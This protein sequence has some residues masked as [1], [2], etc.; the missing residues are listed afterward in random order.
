MSTDAVGRMFTHRSS[1]R[2][3]ISPELLVLQKGLVL[4]SNSLL[5]TAFG[6]A[7]A[8]RRQAVWL[9][10][11][12]DLMRLFNVAPRAVRTSA[13]RLVDGEWLCV[14][15]VGRRS[16]YGLSSTGMLRVALADRR[17][18]EFRL[19]DWDGVWT[20]VMPGATLRSTV[21]RGLEHDLRWQGFGRLS[22]NVFAH[23][24]ADLEALQEILC[25]WQAQTRTSVLSA[26]HNTAF[27][28]EALS[29][30]MQDCFELDD[31]DVAWKQFLAR[32][33][34]LENRETFAP[35]EAFYIRTLLIH[36]YRRVLLRDP[37][38][39]AALLPE[40]WSGLRARALCE[41]IY[42]KVVPPSEIYLQGTVETQDGRLKPTPHVILSR[43]ARGRAD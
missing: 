7:F 41:R 40:G 5:V 14:K 12:I 3:A 30:I 9:G 19:P 43:L 17:I 23:P 8:P 6:D 16:Y 29:R 35:A 32:F 22:R 11:L 10:S 38:V 13:S 36:E 31:V 15:P 18:Y 27:Q 20:M 34:W 42:R 25:A 33:D 21:L 2:D 4:R 1:P 28:F 37:N 26:T 24:R 39:P